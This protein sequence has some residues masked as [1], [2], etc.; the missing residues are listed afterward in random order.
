MQAIPSSQTRSP[1]TQGIDYFLLCSNIVVLSP[2]HTFNLSARIYF[3]G[4]SIRAWRGL[5]FTPLFDF[6]I[7]EEMKE[8][9]VGAE[10]QTQLLYALNTR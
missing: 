5:C 7:K 2:L 9:I 8:V 10:V 3:N 4:I 6:Y 1:S